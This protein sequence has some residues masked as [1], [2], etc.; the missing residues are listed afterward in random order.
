MENVI[1]SSPHRVA[2]K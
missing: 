1:T 2:I